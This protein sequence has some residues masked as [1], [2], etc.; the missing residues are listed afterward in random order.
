LLREAID[1]ARSEHAG[2]F[3]MVEI[4][5]LVRA[6]LER[7]ANLGYH[8]WGLMILFFW[9]KKWGIQTGALAQPVSRKMENA[10]HSIS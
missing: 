10:F 2:F 5:A 9:M 4:E 7:R 3:R 6:H 1:Y 8:L